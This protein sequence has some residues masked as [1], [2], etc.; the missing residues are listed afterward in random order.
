M[1]EWPCVNWAVF[2]GVFIIALSEII[3]LGYYYTIARV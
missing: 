2:A 1:K 3:A